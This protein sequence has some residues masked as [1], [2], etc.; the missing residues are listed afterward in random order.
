[1]ATM[2]T[3]NSAV[4]GATIFVWVLMFGTLW[5]LA[6]AEA[7][8]PGRPPMIQELGRNMAVQY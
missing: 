6:A 2:H 7:V 4:T 5:R 8:H 3:H 1:M